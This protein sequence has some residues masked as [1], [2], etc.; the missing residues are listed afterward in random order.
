MKENAKCS[1]D[2][3]FGKKRVHHTRVQTFVSFSGRLHL[4]HDDSNRRGIN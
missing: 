4:V 3:G 2:V 1:F